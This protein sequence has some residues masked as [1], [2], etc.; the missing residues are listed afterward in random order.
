M[1]M[2]AESYRARTR[3][4]GSVRVR[5]RVRIH[6][7]L[8]DKL[9]VN[10]ENLLDVGENA[11]DVFGSNLGVS[12]KLAH[13]QLKFNKISNRIVNNHHKNKTNQ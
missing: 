7:D 2:R 6:L 1:S 5:V 4:E 10:G 13:E 9:S 11:V 3:V 8:A 12:A